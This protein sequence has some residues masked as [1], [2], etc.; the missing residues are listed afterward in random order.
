MSAADAAGAP[1]GA[2]AVADRLGEVRE[3][4]F[5]RKLREIAE[6]RGAGQDILN[7]GI[8]NPDL[9]PPPAVAAALLGDLRQPGSHGYQP[10]AGTRRWRRALRQWYGER[11]G[12][13]LGE[14]EVLPLTGSKEGIAHLCLAY[15]QPGRAALYP[16]PG[17]P[18]Y[19]A[20]ARLAQGRPL[21][22]PMPEPD[23][24]PAAW[25]QRVG[26]ARG[27]EAPA[28][29][30]VN[31]PHMPTGQVLSRGHL[32]ALVA[33]AKTHDC[34]LVS[35]N[36]YGYYHPDGPTSLLAVPGAREVAV[37]LNSLS[38]SH[39]LAGWR[40]GAL[41]GRPDVLAATL[42]VKSNFDSGQ[43][44]SVQAG[45]SVALTTEWEWHRRQLERI[46]GRRVVGEQLLAE[47]GC[48]VAPDQHGL[49]AWAR[50]PA[51]VGDAEAW[52]DDLLDRHLV[53]VPPGTVFGSGGAGHVRLSLC[54]PTPVLEEAI[55]RVGAQNSGS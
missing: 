43:F 19:A 33:F 53:F 52:C 44:R 14:E 46:A 4:Y 36:A 48:E 11:Y 39:H 15:L 49:F 2:P 41:V 16:D 24:A 21:P 31:S 3:Y 5:S 51:G 38:K 27:G 50:L 17:Y 1:T 9:P 30:F 13:T 45:G 25:V 32:E 35:D 42:R 6:R 47:L 26:A 12:V 22:Y 29:L 8:G 10:Y 40:L 7:L 54:S 37:E 20:A 28:V 23:E 55:R 34:L 18:A